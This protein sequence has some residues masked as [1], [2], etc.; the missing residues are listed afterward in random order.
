VQWLPVR[1]ESRIALIAKDVDRHC[2]I[3]GSR[4]SGSS[5]RRIST[6]SISSRKDYQGQD[7]VIGAR[8]RTT[9]GREVHD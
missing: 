7:V 5:R 1:M 2:R 6:R 8:E 9:D 4:S 3:A